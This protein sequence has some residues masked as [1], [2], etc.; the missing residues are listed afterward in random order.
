MRF[1][2]GQKQL[3]ADSLVKLEITHFAQG[4]DTLLY[5]YTTTLLEIFVDASRCL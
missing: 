5:P 2:S 1:A 4:E 3:S